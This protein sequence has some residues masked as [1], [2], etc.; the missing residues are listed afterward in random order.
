MQHSNHDNVEALIS[1]INPLLCLITAI[2]SRKVIEI[3]L[4][5]HLNRVCNMSVEP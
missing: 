4:M 1:F 5:D 2:S 3:I